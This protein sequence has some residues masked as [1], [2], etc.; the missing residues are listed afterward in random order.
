MEGAM[1]QKLWMEPPPLI[2]ARGIGWE[3]RELSSVS[4][5]NK[6]IR[7]TAFS[8]C[9]IGAPV[10]GNPGEGNDDWG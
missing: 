1:F 2:K 10:Q 3:V 8:V 9:G 4:S 5:N 7:A 6:L